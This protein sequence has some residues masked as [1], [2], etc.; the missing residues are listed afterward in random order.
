[1]IQVTAE[2]QTVGK[3]VFDPI[4]TSIG[5]LMRD[6][7]SVDSEQHQ[8]DSSLLLPPD[9]D[10]SSLDNPDDSLRAWKVAGPDRVSAL[11]EHGEFDVAQLELDDLRSQSVIGM[12]QEASERLHAKLDELQESIKI[13]KNSDST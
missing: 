11:M 5:D 2:L 10:D 6:L 12:D 9:D 3:D 8:V 1:M 7:N 4:L 13:A